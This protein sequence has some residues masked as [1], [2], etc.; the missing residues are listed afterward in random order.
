MT[1]LFKMPLFTEIPESFGF[2]TKLRLIRETDPEKK[3]P[4]AIGPFG[5]RPTAVRPIPARPRRGS[6]GGRRVGD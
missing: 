3:Q 1:L 5:C 4:L 6:A 2:L